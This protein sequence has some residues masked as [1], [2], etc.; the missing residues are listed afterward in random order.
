M[1]RNI[2]ILLIAVL[3]F[4]ASISSAQEQKDWSGKSLSEMPVY[5]M[6]LSDGTKKITR[7]P[8]AVM[9]TQYDMMIQLKRD[10]FFLKHPDIKGT[11]VFS[12]PLHPTVKKLLS[13]TDIFDKFNV[14]SE[15]REFQVELYD[16]PR[17]PILAQK[18]ICAAE[19]AIQS[20]TVDEQKQKIIIKTFPDK[21]N[22]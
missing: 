9:G 19:N 22:D 12:L 16:F 1:K 13:L 11:S 7:L 4:T 10:S 2:N 18:T 20:V 17:L 5:V 14:R 3:L 6:R 8:L 21:P 15:F